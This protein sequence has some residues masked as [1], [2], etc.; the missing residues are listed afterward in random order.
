LL[1]TC[2]NWRINAHA[3]P[4]HAIRCERSAVCAGLLAA[5]A[6]DEMHARSLEGL[7]V[8]AVT[9][10]WSAFN[11]TWH[12]FHSF[13]LRPLRLTP[14]E[15]LAYVAVLR[16]EL[17]GCPACPRALLMRAWI[18]RAVLPAA[19]FKARILCLYLS[20]GVISANTWPERGSCSSCCHSV[21]CLESQFLQQEPNTTKIIHSSICE[22][23]QY[24]EAQYLQLVF[25]V[26]VFRSLATLQ[27]SASTS[28]GH[29]SA[30]MFVNTHAANAISCQNDM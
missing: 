6:A 27:P 24:S 20:P 11:R 25:G 1:I 8:E 23:P 26:A 28:R 18:A 5:D 4:Q 17:A 22:Q 3:L 21:G 19:T 12:V 16:F 2:H 9:K 15:T 29:K 14:A 7:L 10:L 30:D 13:F